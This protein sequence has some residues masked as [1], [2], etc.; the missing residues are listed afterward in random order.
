MASQSDET[1]QKYPFLEESEKIPSG[2]AVVELDEVVWPEDAS[3][4]PRLPD[5][6]WANILDF[7]VPEEVCEVALSGRRLSSAG[8]ASLAAWAQQP[9]V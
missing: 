3:L 6:P 9:T 2:V 5:E 1:L 4:L 8:R 7:L